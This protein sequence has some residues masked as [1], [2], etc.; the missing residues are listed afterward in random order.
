MK[1]KKSILVSLIVTLGMCTSAY[2]GT[3]EVQITTAPVVENDV[4]TWTSGPSEGNDSLLN[5]DDRTVGLRDVTIE[6][7]S[8]GSYTV[9][10]TFIHNR[11]SSKRMYGE[12]SFE[13]RDSQG[14]ELKDQPFMYLG[15]RL[16]RGAH[17]TDSSRT[18]N[19]L[20]WIRDN[21]TTVTR[22]AEIQL[23]LTMTCHRWD[24]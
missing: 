4:A 10:S 13:F 16:K 18:G 19:A 1:E 11:S 15:Y 12:V 20:R 6:L 22:D 7:V 3:S 8:S 2:A 14:N 24:D 17:E 23:W 21:F 9:S 5:C